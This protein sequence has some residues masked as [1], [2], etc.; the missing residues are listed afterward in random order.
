MGEGQE[1]LAPP[2][3]A[4]PHPEVALGDQPAHQVAVERGQDPGQLTQAGGE[5]P[6]PGAGIAGHRESRQR[7]VLVD[8]RAQHRYVVAAQG[9]GAPRPPTPR[10]ARAVRAGP[11]SSPSA[12]RRTS[13]PIRST[14]DGEFVGPGRSQP[15]QPALV[16]ADRVRVVDVEVQV[17]HHEQA[18]PEQTG[19]DTSPLRAPG[20]A[21]PSRTAADGVGEPHRGPALE[22]REHVREGVAAGQEEQ[23]LVHRVQGDRR[24]GV[25]ARTAQLAQIAHPVAAHPR[26][27]G[28]PQR[29]VPAH[30]G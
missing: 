28:G 21:R 7:G 8:Q 16:A 15:P 26:A 20:A 12:N 1:V 19:P 14:S 24:V 27:A 3:L 10:P 2:A 6:S 13:A 5:L 11:V 29:Q 9:A 23:P 18:Q 4:V 22:H 17:R 30:L 25:A